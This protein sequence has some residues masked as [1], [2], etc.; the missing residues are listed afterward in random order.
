MIRPEFGEPRIH[1][2]LVCAAVS[3]PALRGEAYVGSR[4]DRQ[5]NDQSELF[6]NDVEQVRF[7]SVTGRLELN[8]ILKWYG[9]DW[10]QR[11]PDGGYLAW[12]AGLVQD[13]ELGSAIRRAIDGQVA[14]DWLDYD[15]SLNRLGPTAAGGGVPAGDFGSGSIPND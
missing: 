1:V 4:I 14:I 7:N 11:Y 15:W 9:E 3:C 2:A 13:D 12:L 8:P 5:L 10:D 6:A